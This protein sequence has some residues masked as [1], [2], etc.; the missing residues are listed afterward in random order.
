MSPMS[1]SV[2]AEY[3]AAYAAHVRIVDLEEAAPDVFT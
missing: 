1:I 2:S 3:V